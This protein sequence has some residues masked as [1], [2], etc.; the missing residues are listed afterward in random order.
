M[1]KTVPGRLLAAL[2]DL[3]E[4]EFKKFKEMLLMFVV[5]ETYHLSRHIPWGLLKKADDACSIAD[6]LLQYYG[7]DCALEVTV[8]VLRASG[9][10]GRALRLDATRE[11]ALQGEN[12]GGTFESS[13]KYYTSCLLCSMTLPEKNW[14]EIVWDPGRNREIYRLDVTE[15]GSIRCGITDLMFDIKK[16]VTITYHF[17]SWSGYMDEVKRADLMVAGPLLNIQAEPVEAVAA[18]HFPHFLCLAGGGDNGVRIAHFNKGTMILRRPDRVE[19]FHVILYNLRFSPCAV[20][21]EKSWLKQE[22]KV[23][24]IVLLYQQPKYLNSMLHLYVLPSDSSLKKAVYG[25]E[26]ILC[27]RRLLKPPG[28]RYP[29]KF[30]S[31]LFLSTSD[32]SKVFSEEV[33]F[34]YTSP[35]K[36]QELFFLDVRQMKDELELNLMEEKQDVP[37]WTARVRR[38]ELLLNP[39]LGKVDQPSKETRVP[40]SVGQG[41]MHGDCSPDIGDISGLAGGRTQATAV[42]SGLDEQRMET[43]IDPEPSEECPMCSS[44]CSKASPEKIWPTVVQDPKRRRKTYRLH[45]TEACS[46]R[47][48]ITDLIFDIKTAVTI[49]YHFDSWS[50]YMDDIRKAHL[51][52][53]GPLLNIQADPADAVVAV[54]FP[55]ILCLAGEDPYQV[56]IAH[57][58]EEGMILEKPDRVENFHVVLYNPKFSLLGAICKIPFLKQKIKVHAIVLL[59]QQLRLPYPILHLYLL[60]NDSSLKQAVHDNE[61]KWSNR[62]PKPPGTTR[63]LK[64]ETCYFVRT[65]HDVKISPEELILRYLDVDMEQQY[66]ELCARNMEDELELNLIEKNKDASIWTSCVRREELTLD[67]VQGMQAAVPLE[68]HFIDRHREALIQWTAAVEGILDM[69]YGIIL[70]EEQ[71]RAISAKRTNQ[72]KMRELYQLVPS[73]NRDCKDKLYEAIKKKNKFLIEDLEHQS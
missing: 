18:V 47:C 24:A 70:D 8:R 59:Y 72:D 4:D 19:G 73:W 31:R 63:P 23:H 6:L 46:I 22:I 13:E 51:T 15:A 14:P 36:M 9:C 7:E 35:G 27:S 30:G 39:I 37:V 57:F 62:V 33:V 20:V 66:L 32:G 69:L 40:E 53:A 29:L 43:K 25:I 56:S 71:Y 5:S 26:D 48:G 1:E 67:S 2:Q 41:S 65:S 3:T 28:T 21:L 42:P 64:L 45:V 50:G 55:H 16:A 17:D 61:V 54:H 38:E 49:T 34:K 68:Q 12:I 11:I 52:V 58:T 10:K 60:P 44:L